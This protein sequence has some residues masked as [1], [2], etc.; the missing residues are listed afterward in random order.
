M[1]WEQSSTL[2]VCPS[3]A[4]FADHV[5]VHGSRNGIALSEIAADLLQISKRFRVLDAFDARLEPEAAAQFDDGLDH[6][7]RLG[8]PIRLR[9]E[10]VVD[11]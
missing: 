3:G 2:E 4:P 6:R 9:H 8:R 1:L 10:G 11:A 5:V 7:A